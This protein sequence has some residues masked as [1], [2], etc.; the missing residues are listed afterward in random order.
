MKN[1]HKDMQLQDL[2]ALL[3]TEQARK[4]DFV[5]QGGSLSMRGGLLHVDDSQYDAGLQALLQG[6]G[7]TTQQGTVALEPMEKLHRDLADKLGIPWKY[8][9]RLRTDNPGL[10]DENVS[11]WFANEQYNG[12]GYFL[13][14]F[15]D[16]DGGTGVARCLLSDRYHVLD[17]LDVVYAALEAVKKSGVNVTIDPSDL[18]DE[19]IFMRVICPDVEVEA[20]ELLDRYKVPGDR[21]RSNYDNPGGICTGFIL[22]NSEVG[23]GRFTITPRLVV[24]KCANGMIFKSEAYGK[25]HLGTKQEVGTSIQWSEE[26]EQKNMALIISQV[27]DAVRTFLSPGFLGSMVDTLR[28][29]SEHKVEHTRKAVE[30]VGRALALPEKRMDDLVSFFAQG[31]DHTAL[32]MGQAITYLAQ[33][34]EPQ[35]RYELEM[36][37]VSVMQSAVRWDVPEELKDK[38]LAKVLN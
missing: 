18:S 22:R 37:A 38:E 34:E 29:A 20:P 2:Y 21:G 25:Q 13:R 8:Y 32:G 35:R 9:D 14:T 16:Q 4:N 11:R 12:K 10:L 5:L 1:L 3:Q 28:Q 19:A 6:T 15:T 36:A 7:A 31:G 30:N 27:Q 17:N 24:G 26:T 23:S 33:E